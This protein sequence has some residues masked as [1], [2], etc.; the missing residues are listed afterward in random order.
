MGFLP[1]HFST[2]GEKIVYVVVGVAAVMLVMQNK[3][4]KTVLKALPKIK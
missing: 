4:F 3:M 2:L 1:G